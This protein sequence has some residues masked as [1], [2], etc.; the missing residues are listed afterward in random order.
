MRTPG[1]A[2]GRQCAS[3]HLAATAPEPGWSTLPMTMSPMAAGSIP[4]FS[5]TAL[6]TTASRSSVVVFLK[7]CGEPRAPPGG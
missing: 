6:S 4:D 3:T 2:Y 7:T 1:T 5:T